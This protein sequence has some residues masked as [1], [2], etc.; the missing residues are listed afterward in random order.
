MAST[1]KEQQELTVNLRQAGNSLLGP[2]D[3][4]IGNICDSIC[5]ADVYQFP[6]KECCKN[7]QKSL[8]FLLPVPWM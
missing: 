3:I 1:N 8:S 5:L 7:L 6:Q 4:S 2:F